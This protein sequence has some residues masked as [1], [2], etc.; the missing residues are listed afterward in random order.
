MTPPVP[1]AVKHPSTTTT[2]AAKVKTTPKRVQLAAL[3]LSDNGDRLALPI[4]LGLGLLA[5][6]A[7]SADIVRRQGSTLLQKRKLR[8][9]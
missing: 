3:H 9:P 8:Q 6:V 4:I 7:S 1:T 5:I 2:T